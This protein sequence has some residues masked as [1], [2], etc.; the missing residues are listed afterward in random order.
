MDTGEMSHFDKLVAGQRGFLLDA[1][2]YDSTS[3]LNNIYN[4]MFNMADT[5]F[6]SKIFKRLFCS[7]WTYMLAPEKQDVQ[8]RFS[9][10]F[11][12]KIRPPA[13]VKPLQLVGRE[14]F[15]E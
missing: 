9:P 8:G 7:L 2:E 1:M 11:G 14:N 12:L 6:T 15:L 4:M 5:K 3:I 13:P 10:F